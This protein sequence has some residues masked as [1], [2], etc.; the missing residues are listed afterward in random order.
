MNAY[1]DTNHVAGL[2]LLVTT[3]AWGM[4]ELSQRSQPRR[5]G[6]TV[7]GGAGWR[8][9]MLTCLIATVVVVNLTPHVFPAAAIRPGYPGS[10]PNTSS[11][12]ADLGSPPKTSRWNPIP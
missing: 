11:I 10:C 3:Q 6:A 2:L 1:F 12:H 4:M 5:E 9:V 7:V 8:F